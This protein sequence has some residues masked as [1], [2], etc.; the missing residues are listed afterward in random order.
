[1]VVNLLIEETVVNEAVRYFYPSEVEL[2]TGAKAA[3]GAF[4]KN[5]LICI[6]ICNDV[7]IMLLEKVILVV[8]FFLKCRCNLFFASS[9]LVLYFTNFLFS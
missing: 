9:I 5:G 8:L 7:R 3:E 2:I 4:L 1:M 6:C